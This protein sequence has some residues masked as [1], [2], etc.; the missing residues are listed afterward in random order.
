M[1][2]CI[3][4]RMMGPENT[5]GIG[6]YIEELVRHLLAL[7]TDDRFVLVTRSADHP[8]KNHPRVET[9]AADIPWYGLAEQ[10]KLP[11][12][13]RR[14]KADLIHVPHWNA[15]LLYRGPLVVTVH[16][17]LLRHFPASAKTSTRTWLLRLAKRLLYR[18]VVANAVRHAR[19]ILV[20]TE[21]VKQDVAYFFPSAASKIM[22][23]GEGMPKPELPPVPSPQS[24]APSYFL[25]VGSAYPHKGLGDLL[26]A[27]PTIHGRY[28]GLKL[29]IA[30]E[31]DV[32]MTRYER[33]VAE[34]GLQDVEFL[35]RVSD[36]GLA[37]LYGDASALV[38]PTH[39]EGFGLPPLEALAHG[40]PVIASDIPVLREVLGKNGAT[41]FRLGDTDG[42]LAAVESV[43]AQPEKSRSA[44]RAAA[45]ELQARH[46][47]PVSA[48]L[49]LR[50]YGQSVGS[51]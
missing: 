18:V 12:V 20:P 27:W 35:G 32:F 25:Y 23:T 47:W 40:C 10:L 31:K 41:Y 26:D 46:S 44:A 37:R 48:A 51:A 6:R 45:F 22:V 42:I 39:F 43:L 2:I 24:P 17:L 50:A 36:S 9:L 4:A 30:G 5:R 15:P 19:R 7:G 3:D 49:T 38:F 11:S 33:R 1:R 29:K 16:D 28:P 13:F 14:A 34:F 8:F 21:F